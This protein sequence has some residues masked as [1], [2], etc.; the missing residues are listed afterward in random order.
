VR[1]ILCPE[2]NISH[3]KHR[4][5]PG[6]VFE[7]DVSNLSSLATKLTLTP[8]KWLAPIERDYPVLEKAYGYAKNQQKSDFYGYRSRNIGDI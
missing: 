1:R 8:K 6:L 2:I 5:H 4:H 3:N 7:E